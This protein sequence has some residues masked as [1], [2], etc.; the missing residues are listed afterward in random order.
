MDRVQ[1]KL[2]SSVPLHDVLNKWNV[3]GGGGDEEMQPSK[4]NHFI[5]PY[6]FYTYSVKY[7]AVE[8]LKNGISYLTHNYC[9]A[10][11]FFLWRCS[12]SLGLGIPS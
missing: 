3:V 4:F 5:Y 8:N 6:N 11:F 1:N 7:G 10:T 2:N 9:K 12:P